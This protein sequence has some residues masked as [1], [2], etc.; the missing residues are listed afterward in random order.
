MQPAMDLTIDSTIA[1][2]D[3]N[4]MPRLGL[5]VWQ[6]SSG[7]SCESAV[8][9]ALDVGYRHIDTAAFYGNESSVG[10]A[11]RD[12][13]IARGEIYVTTKLWNSDHG[14]VE[15]AFDRSLAKLKLDYVDLYL[16]HYPVP[17][18]L[19][20]WRV[21]EKLRAGGKVRSIGV[22][23]FTVRHLTE[24]IAKAEIVPAANQVELHPYLYQRELLDFCR[25][26]IIVVQAYS[27]L[28][29]G[30]RLKDPKLVAM[31]KKYGN[32]SPAQILIRWALQ[33]DVVVLPKSANRQ[34]IVE[35]ADVFDFAISA[36]DMAELDGFNEELRTCWD[37]TRAP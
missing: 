4:R 37:P 8:R 5:G 20:S 1:L 27:P 17:E 10:Q 26:K 33:H 35:N 25:E 28:T 13:G 11:I 14:N 31:A 16:I 21:L 34:R 18:R 7:K 36:A 22:S 9:A 12:S 23:N 6:I 2:N 24:L 29:H 19:R 3:G 32:K 15:K 30:E